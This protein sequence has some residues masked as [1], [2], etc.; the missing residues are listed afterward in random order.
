[1]VGGK[2]SLDVQYKFHCLV[3]EC[4]KRTFWWLHTCKRHGLMLNNSGLH[5]ADIVRTK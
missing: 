1:M 3:T 2:W 5:L 4:D